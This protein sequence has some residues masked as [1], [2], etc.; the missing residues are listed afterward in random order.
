MRS[1]VSAADR[2]PMPRT[3]ACSCCW[4][5][6]WRCRWP[7]SAQTTRLRLVSTAWTPFT[8]DHRA[9]ALRAR[10]GRSRVRAALASARPRRSLKPRSSPLAAEGPVRR[11]RRGVERCRAGETRCSFRT[12]ISKTGWSWWAGRARWSPRPRSP[13]SRASGSRLSAAT[14]TATIDSAGPTFVQSKTEED[15]L[16]LLL[17]SKVDYTLMDELVVQYIATNYA[18]EAKTHLRD[19]HHAPVDAAAL[20][21]RAA[22]AA[23]RRVDRHALQRPAPQHDCRS[24]LPSP[25]ARGLDQRG[26]RWRWPCRVRAADRSGRQGRAGPAPTQLLSTE[27]KPKTTRHAAVLPRRQG[28]QRVDGRAGELQSLGVRASPIRTNRP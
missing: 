6:S 3:W 4:C 28:L 10:P 19:G 1:V 20:S 12:R 21:G 27:Q 5:H 11:Q 17:A 16:S 23:G 7:D 26:R 24:H 8:N 15:S 13:V 25:S 18:L 9:A 2:R 22:F 14:R